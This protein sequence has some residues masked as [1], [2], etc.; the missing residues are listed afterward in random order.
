MDG[1]TQHFEFLKANLQSQVR[2]HKELLDN[3]RAEKVALVAASIS[4]IRDLTHVK[5]ALVFEIQKVETERKRWLADFRK[6]FSIAEETV[7]LEK[8]ISVLGGQYHEELTRLKISVLTLAKRVKE[9]SA[10]NMSL[11]E[12]AIRE[13]TSMKQIALG[14]SSLNQTYGKNGRVADSGKNPRLISREI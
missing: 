5:E 14:M 3:M 1:K 12:N 8:V 6:Q 13:A 7:D 10:E 4:V 11:T 9:L 2:L